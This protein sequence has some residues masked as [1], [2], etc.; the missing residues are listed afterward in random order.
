MHIT[1]YDI[2]RVLEQIAPFH[3]AESWDNSGLQIGRLDRIVKT[4]WI[5]LDPLPEVIEAACEANA[6][7][8]ITHHPLIFQP[9]KNIRFD[10][11]MGRSIIKSANH[12]LTIFSMHTNYDSANGG[13][14]DIL[15][16]KLGLTHVRVLN[17]TLNIAISVD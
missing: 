17:K 15:A 8:L 13:M 16:E 3:L 2:V 5:A 12:D 10:T 14:N 11:P 9:L 4:I 6:D 7:L 1:V